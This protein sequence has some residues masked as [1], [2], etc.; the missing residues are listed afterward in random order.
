M[1]QKWFS[2]CWW[3]RLRNLFD[4]IL[5]LKIFKE[6]SAKRAL[7]RMD[8]ETKR[9]RAKERW[10][11]RNSWAELLRNCACTPT[12]TANLSC[13]LDLAYEPMLRRRM[14]LVS[15]TWLNLLHRV[16]VQISI[17]IISKFR[18]LAIGQLAK[19][20]WAE[21]KLP[22][23]VGESTQGL[24]YD[25]FANSRW[26]AYFLDAE[27]LASRIIIWLEFCKITWSAADE[28]ASTCEWSAR[29][30][31]RRRRRL[32]ILWKVL[33]HLASVDADHNTFKG[34]WK[35]MDKK[36][37]SKCNGLAWPSDG[38]AKFFPISLIAS[39]IVWDCSNL[40]PVVLYCSADSSFRSSC[41]TTFNLG[42][43]LTGAMEY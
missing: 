38:D 12:T 4:L 27:A 19:S 1:V 9:R 3:C 37:V 22:S 18:S 32:A 23:L 10:A 39:Q 34:D 7:S 42:A 35:C 36:L 24:F 25:C 16:L 21:N 17:M 41:K 28:S 30:S 29:A 2:W 15:S 11:T 43:I 13:F 8:F 31:R 26:P 6:A 33:F 40:R 5:N 20:A 14:L